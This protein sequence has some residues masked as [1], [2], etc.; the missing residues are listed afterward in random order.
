M[1][2]R[3]TTLSNVDLNIHRDICDGRRDQSKPIKS[4]TTTTQQINKEL[5]QIENRIEARLRAIEDGS[6]FRESKVDVVAEFNELKQ[7]RFW[8][9]EIETRLTEHLDELAARQLLRK[10]KLNAI[11]Q[12]TESS[13]AKRDAAYAKTL[14]E[15]EREFQR[16]TRQREDQDEISRVMAK[17]MQD[18][19]DKTR[20]QEEGAKSMIGRLMTKLR[21]GGSKRK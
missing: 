21:R 16:A 14:L 18:E 4:L 11:Q 9:T 19:E 8:R 15:T 2:A 1:T 20:R 10:E 5:Q 12:S 3:R 13:P 6:Q 17:C 7:D